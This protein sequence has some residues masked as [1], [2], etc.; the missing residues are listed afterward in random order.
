[1][2]GVYVCTH[3][4]L[5]HMGVKQKEVIKVKRI[6]NIWNWA[7]SKLLRWCTVTVDWRPRATY[8]C[9]PGQKF[10]TF[11]HSHSIIWNIIRILEY[12]TKFMDKV[13]DGWFYYIAID[14]YDFH[15]DIPLRNE[16]KTIYR[17]N[18]CVYCL[19]L[20]RCLYFCIY[21]LN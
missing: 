12:S 9:I 17:F 11:S 1:M 8:T 4:H 14:V 18:I 21:S 15:F 10:I 6:Y 20:E 16:C 7:N 19:W 3:V 5:Y 13:Y 2:C